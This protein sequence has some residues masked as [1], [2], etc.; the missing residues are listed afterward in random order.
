M[1]ITPR[2]KPSAHSLLKKSVNDL[3]GFRSHNRFII[4]SEVESN[5]IPDIIDLIFNLAPGGTTFLD[6]STKK[7]KV[8]VINQSEVYGDVHGRCDTRTR[9]CYMHYGFT[10]CTADQI[11]GDTVITFTDMDWNVIADKP[12]NGSGKNK[13]DLMGS[14]INVSYDK[15]ATGGAIFRDTSTYN[16]ILIPSP[17]YYDEKDMLLIGDKEEN[18]NDVLTENKSFN[19]YN[20]FNDY[21]DNLYRLKLNDLIDDHTKIFKLKITIENLSSLGANFVGDDSLDEVISEIAS[22][23]KYSMEI[24]GFSSGEIDLGG[25]SD[26]FNFHNMKSYLR[27]EKDERYF[28][29]MMFVNRLSE[30][31][32]NYY[33]LPFVLMFNMRADKVNVKVIDKRSLINPNIGSDEDSQSLSQKLKLDNSYNIKYA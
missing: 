31:S 23:L 20:S 1:L 25:T 26:G 2:A 18:Y 13:F 33:D 10:D 32:D 4:F 6:S 12:Y 24:S 19:F 30:L 8:M 29:F 22:E 17:E 14:D 11:T 9:N 3:E 16:E 21:Y 7:T 15:D 28:H 27:M 5:T